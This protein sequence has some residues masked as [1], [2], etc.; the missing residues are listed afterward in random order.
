MELLDLIFG[1]GFSEDLKLKMSQLDKRF[2]SLTM[3]FLLVR[4]INIDGR[5][6]FTCVFGSWKL[7][8][9]RQLEEPIYEE[10]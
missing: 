9:G 6:R 8:F 7:K 1:F 3:S 4:F 5:A 2:I 10:C